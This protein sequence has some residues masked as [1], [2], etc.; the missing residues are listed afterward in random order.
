VVV[1]ALERAAERVAAMPGED[2]PLPVEA[3][4]ADGL[5]ALC[6]AAISADRDP[7]RATVVLH[8]RVDA[9]GMLTEAEIE[10]GAPVA[11]I[12]RRAPAV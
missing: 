2:G 1:R 8:A 11:P 12:G 3:R 7:D 10:G 6:S 4:R 9:A 5:L